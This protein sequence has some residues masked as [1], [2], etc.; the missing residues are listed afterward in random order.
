[1]VTGVPN[2]FQ[3]AVSSDDCKQW[4]IAREH[5]IK[6]FRDNNVSEIV[7]Q[8]KDRVI[9]GGRWV[10]GIKHNANDQLDVKTAYLNA[11]VD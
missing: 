8:P 11:P 7:E 3:E 2:S 5:E 10:F 1:M 6:I 9:V 4:Q